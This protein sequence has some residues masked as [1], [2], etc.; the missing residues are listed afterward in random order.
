MKWVNKGHEYES[1]SGIFE[2]EKKIYVWGAG[3][4]GYAFYEEFKPIFQIVAFIDSNKDKQ[5][6]T[7]C[8]LPVLSPDAFFDE[9]DDGIVVVSTGQTKSV[10]D[11][12]N[13]NHFVR[14]KD[15]FHIDEWSSIYNFYKN[16]IVFVS[17]LTLVITQKCTLKCK[18]CNAFMPQIAHPKDV[19]LDNIKKDLEYY[20]SWVDSVNVLG[21]CG[22][23]A[24]AHSNFKDVLCYIGEEYYPARIKHIE[25]YSNAVI[26]PDAEVLDMFKK[27]NII[28]R[29]TDYG[30]NSGKQRIKE[31]IKVLESHHIMYDHA[32]FKEWY[33]CGYP[34]ESNGI[35]EE[36]KLIKF[37]TACDRKTCHS[38]HNGRLFTCGMCLSADMIG[39]CEIK[40][41]DYFDLRHYDK[42]KRIEF[43]EYYLGYS[44]RGYY[45][46]CKKCN[47]GTNINKKVITVGEQG[48]KMQNE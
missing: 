19:V 13:K 2:A 10:Y 44:T 22:G 6:K 36:E 29:F 1:L 43:L 30:S 42:D 27:Y 9:F 4:F 25:V 5:N 8:N 40:E 32:K 17:D 20:F 38:L 28:Y 18:Y 48:I 14:H 35:K 12:L 39:Y 26:I 15:Y 16:E 23:D 3:T 24:M 11:E 46:Y 34:Q 33:D 31:V 47:G 7:F 45:E 21:L 37:C 41:E